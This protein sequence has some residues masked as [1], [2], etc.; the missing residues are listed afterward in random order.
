MVPCCSGS[1]SLTDREAQ[2]SAVYEEMETSLTLVGVTAIEDKLQDGVPEAIA[3]LALAD[4]S[5][6]STS[7]RS[8]YL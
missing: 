1:T 6:P 7:K 3:N 2:L 4:T 5:S 8:V